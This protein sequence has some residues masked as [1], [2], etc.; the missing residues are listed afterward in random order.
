MMWKY[1]EKQTKYIMMMAFIN[2]N[3]NTNSRQEMLWNQWISNKS[4]NIYMD[5]VCGCKCF[6]IVS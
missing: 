6:Q 5:N 3:F 1:C 2:D 4:L